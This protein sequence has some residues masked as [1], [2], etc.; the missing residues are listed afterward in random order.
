MTITRGSYSSYTAGGLNQT[1]FPQALTALTWIQCNYSWRIIQA[2]F[3]VAFQ[4]DKL[5]IKCVPKSLILFLGINAIWFQAFF[6]SSKFSPAL[7]FICQLIITL[8]SFSQLIKLT[9]LKLDKAFP[10]MENFLSTQSL[11][12][13]WTVSITTKQKLDYALHILPC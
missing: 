3:E 12:P 13:H 10:G 5:I 1:D 4:M 11:Q 6:I 9:H 8:A 7:P 2:V